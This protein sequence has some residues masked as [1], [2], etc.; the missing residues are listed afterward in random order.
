MPEQPW[1]S[2]PPTGPLLRPKQA[3]EYLGIG[4]ATYYE[5][6]A[7][8]TLPKPI[9]LST[10]IKASGIPRPWLDAIIAQAAA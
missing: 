5:H 7:N 2:T 4:V 10:G 6:A 9:Q 8:G 3:A 1:K